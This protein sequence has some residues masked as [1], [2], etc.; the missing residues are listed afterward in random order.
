MTATLGQ[1]LAWHRGLCPACTR[2]RACPEYLEIT[3][4]FTEP[5][6]IWAGPVAARV[7]LSV[8]EGTAT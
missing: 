1:V 3:G 4:E 2:D 6:R 5:R 8:R 7:T